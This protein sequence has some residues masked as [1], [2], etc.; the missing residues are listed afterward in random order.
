MLIQEADAQSFRLNVRLEFDMILIEHPVRFVGQLDVVG[1]QLEWIRLLNS[2]IVI[3][4][5]TSKNQIRKNKQNP[6]KITGSS[7]SLLTTAAATIAA[8]V[9]TIT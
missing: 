3:F 8:T 5:F 2:E 6:L 9:T 7:W 1:V 4:Y